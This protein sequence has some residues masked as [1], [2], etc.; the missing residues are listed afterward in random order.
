MKY[1]IHT[2]FTVIMKNPLYFSSTSSRK[3]FFRKKKQQRPRFGKTNHAR[4][5]FITRT[6][7]S[8]NRVFLEKSTVLRELL[9]FHKLLIVELHSVLMQL[10]WQS[11]QN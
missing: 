3:E 9:S 7:K 4:F 8:Q 11:F 2:V 6:I 10:E 1:I 5:W